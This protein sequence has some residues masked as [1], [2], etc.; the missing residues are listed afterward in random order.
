[1]STT[2]EKNVVTSKEARD[3]SFEPA[4]LE[5][6]T[7][8]AAQYTIQLRPDHGGFAGTVAAFPAVMGH[9]ASRSAAVDTTRDLLKWA[10]AYLIET[11]RPPTPRE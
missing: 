7:G 2:R 11:G 9:G 1:M 3:R 8:L 6:A 5:Q 10:I 4:V